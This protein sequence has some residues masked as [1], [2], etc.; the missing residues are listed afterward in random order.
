MC[1]PPL[2]PMG[3]LAC[4]VKYGRGP[5]ELKQ[6]WFTQKP[7]YRPENA[8]RNYTWI[9]TFSASL[10]LCSTT[11]ACSAT[12]EH[13]DFD[14]ASAC[15]NY[16]QTLNATFFIYKAWDLLQD[17]PMEDSMHRL[18]THGYIS[19][20]GVH[21]KLY[22]LLRNYA[23]VLIS[24]PPNLKKKRKENVQSNHGRLMKV[25]IGA[26]LVNT[27]EWV[28]SSVQLIIQ[29]KKYLNDMNNMMSN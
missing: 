24:P 12:A 29:K 19:N 14:V 26:E 7:I 15:C 23:N 8:E 21:L 16:V 3:F 20:Q 17:T 22:W 5:K 13:F 27:G 18:R 25:L 6:K 2:P 10:I 4:A 1:P 28:I 11:S 9:D